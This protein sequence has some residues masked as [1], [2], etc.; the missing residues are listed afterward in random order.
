M[1]I[2]HT[3]NYYNYFI[4][5]G[6][7]PTQNLLPHHGSVANSSVQESKRKAQREE[8][9]RKR[10]RKS[11]VEDLLNSS[12][13]PLIE[14]LL[15][16]SDDLEHVTSEASPSDFREDLDTNNSNETSQSLPKA[17]ATSVKP[18]IQKADK[19]VQVLKLIFLKLQS[20]FQHWAPANNLCLTLLFWL[21][22]S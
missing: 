1:N 8:R 20:Q 7:V 3:L 12:P 10:I 9:A 2:F 14:N 15:G 22:K 5:E 11:I 19:S 16:V 6:A 4:F 18:K 21:F 13:T 17:D